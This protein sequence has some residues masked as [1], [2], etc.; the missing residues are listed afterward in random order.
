MAEYRNLTGVSAMRAALTAV[1]CGILLTGLGVTI[2]WDH[3][4]WPGEVYTTA[5]LI[6]S[7]ETPSLAKRQGTYY[8]FQ[9]AVPG[10]RQVVLS[11]MVTRSGSL[12]RD[13]DSV[14]VLYAPDAPEQ[15]RLWVSRG[16]AEFL[17]TLGGIALAFVGLWGVIHELLK[18][19]RRRQATR[20]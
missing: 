6:S 7:A 16:G 5:T 18:R 19:R 20:A 14:T 4:G 13:G 8:E 12:Y 1:M 2:I 11:E 9:Y 10:G 15:G 3:R 17:P